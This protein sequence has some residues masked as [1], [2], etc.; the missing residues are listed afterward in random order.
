[1]EGLVASKDG[2]VH[3]GLIYSFCCKS[4]NVVLLVGLSGMGERVGWGNVRIGNVEVNM[5]KLVL[6]MAQWR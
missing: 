1:M 3:V 6:G 4:W 2:G 5:L